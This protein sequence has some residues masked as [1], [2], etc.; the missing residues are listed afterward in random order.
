MHTFYTL[1]ELELPL[2]LRTSMTPLADVIAAD[3]DIEVQ[4]DYEPG[5]HEILRA[6]PNDSQ[7]G[8]PDGVEVYEVRCVDDIVFDNEGI[9]LTLEAG[10]DLTHL[11]PRSVFDQIEHDLITEI[12]NHREAA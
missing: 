3:V 6:D 12:R 5:Q 10:Y 2:I 11:L 1:A 8:F 7:P 4:Y 9:K